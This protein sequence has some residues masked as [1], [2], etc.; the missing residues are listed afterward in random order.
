MSIG[1][2]IYELRTAKNMSQGDLA[3]ELDVS[4]QSV[5][6]WETDAA[7]PDLDKLIRLADVFEV[8]LDELTGRE[9]PHVS[10]TRE[11]V[12]V[13][14][15]GI[16]QRQIIGY[17]LLVASLIGF[18]LTIIFVENDII[19]TVTIPFALVTLFGSII[20]LWVKKNV[21]YCFTW[22]LIS[23]LGI[24]IVFTYPLPIISS[25]LGVQ[26]I[27]LLLLAIIGNKI[28]KNEEIKP[29]K[30]KNQMLAVGWVLCIVLYLIVMFF[31]PGTVLWCIETYVIYFAIS[32]LM[33]YTI[34]YVKC[35]KTH[36]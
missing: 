4:R 8:S 32:A 29:S 34:A 30:Q 23:M 16:T 12:E 15:S 22:A 9:M 18:I 36:K 28:Y 6:K 7:V 25:T 19:S 3:N 5:S 10:T 13:K 17:I 35:L 31:E 27:S 2:K 21:G 14:Q 26:I 24:F 33:T 20:C 1:Q 11:Q